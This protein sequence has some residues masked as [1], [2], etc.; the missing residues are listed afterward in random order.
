MIRKILPESAIRLY[1]LYNTIGKKNKT[2]FIQAIIRGR[3]FRFKKKSTKAYNYTRQFREIVHALPVKSNSWYF[4]PFDSF[5]MRDRG[6]FPYICSVTV[7]YSKLLNSTTADLRKQVELCLN[8]EFKK[9]LSSILDSLEYL[10]EKSEKSLANST[11]KRSKIVSQFICNIKNTLPSTFDEALQKILFFN[12]LFWQM[13]HWHVGLGRLDYVLWPYYRHDVENG[14]L[15][16]SEGKKLLKEFVLTLGKDMYA[17]SASLDG[18]TGQYIMLGG[19]DKMGCNVDNELTQMFLEL[20]TELNI[21]DPKLIL[22]ANN[23][24]SEEVWSNSIN[25]ITTGCGSPLIMNEHLIM[26]GMIE[27]GYKKEDVWNMGTSACWEPL[28][29]GKSFDQNNPFRNIAVVQSL[30]KILYSDTPIFSYQDLIEALKKNLSQ[31][32]A[33]TIRDIDFD[34]S[35]LYSLF[36]DSCIEREKE[37]SKGGADYSYHGLEI[38]SFPNLI[39]SILNLKKYVYEDKLF[40][41]DDIRK[42]LQNNFT[43]YED[44]RTILL[45]NPLKYGKQDETVISLTNEFMQFISKEVEQH[46]CNGHKLKVGFSSSAYLTLSKYA[47]ATVDGRYNGEPFAV[48]ISPLSKDID[49]NEILDFA[50]S[51]DYS[52]NRMNG[53]VVDFILPKSYLENKEKLIAILKHAMTSGVYELQLN[54][55]DAETLKDAKLHP[56]KYLNLVVRV[57]G[58]SAYFND[59]PDEYKD[60]LIKR[61]ESYGC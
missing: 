34:V 32:I 28:I 52:G 53:N 24:T 42:A 46:K 56:E 57:W 31:Q 55:L 47:K 13:D 39:N 33:N 61:A 51:L 17:K 59:L 58:F 25:C 37:F 35:P 6:N 40:T 9:S 49:I 26:K 11:D 8:K 23:Q 7:D 20:F 14:I 60:N 36:F 27:F 29:I 4:Y 45:S 12:A 30:N 2:S 38:L 3:V 22:R 5:L 48:H 44:M 1:A 54:V 43:N 15:S 41:I 21:P 10:I 50:G 18:D 19:I 16:S